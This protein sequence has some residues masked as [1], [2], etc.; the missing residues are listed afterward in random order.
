MNFVKFVGIG[1]ETGKLGG[2]PNSLVRYITKDLKKV[3]SSYKNQG[4]NYSTHEIVLRLAD[5]WRTHYPRTNKYGTYAFVNDE[6]CI[7]TQ[8][9]PSRILDGIFQDTY[10]MMYPKNANE[11]PNCFVAGAVYNFMRSRVQ[12][13]NGVRFIDSNIVKKIHAHIWNSCENRWSV[14]SMDEIEDGYRDIYEVYLELDE[15]V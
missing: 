6:K 8:I 1:N 12:L 13:I 2:Y 4:L 10:A 7:N 14:M 11:K 3:V 15:G 5:V 9:V